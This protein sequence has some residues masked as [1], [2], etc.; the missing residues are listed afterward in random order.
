MIKSMI[1]TTNRGMKK[2]DSKTE[3]LTDEAYRI[4]A[5]TIKSTR[6]DF[7]WPNLAAIIDNISVFLQFLMVVVSSVEMAARTLEGEWTSAQKRD[8]AGKIVDEQTDTGWLDFFDGKVLGV[9]VSLA[10]AVQNLFF[11]KDWLMNS[12]GGKRQVR[13][14]AAALVH[15]NGEE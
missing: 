5:K 2:M 1:I 4:F 12:R 11:G 6:S 7:N 10:V 3:K 8:A 13:P 14:E 9:L 15:V